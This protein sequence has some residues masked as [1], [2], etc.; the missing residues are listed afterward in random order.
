MK[1]AA[2]LDEDDQAILDLATLHGRLTSG[3]IVDNLHVS[4]ATATRRLAALVKKGLLAKRG[5]GRGTHYVL[6]ETETPAAAEPWPQRLQEARR[7][8]APAHPLAALEVI[9]KQP[10]PLLCVGARFRERPTLAQFLQLEE[11][12]SKLLQTRVNLTLVET[13]L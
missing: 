5:K 7:A 10:Q 9:A 2:V 1:S 11:E 6:A 4:K 13:I 8:L 12:L 3:L